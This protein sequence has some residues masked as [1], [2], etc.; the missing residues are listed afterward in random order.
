[1]NNKGVS[2]NTSTNNYV[3]HVEV[4]CSKNEKN[5]VTRKTMTQAQDDFDFSKI[6]EEEIKEAKHRID[7]II[8]K[9]GKY[10]VLIQNKVAGKLINNIMRLWSR[11]ITNAYKDESYLT[12]TLPVSKKTIYLSKFLSSII[13]LF[14][15]SIVIIVSLFIAYYSKENL[16]FLKDSLTFIATIYDSTMIKMLLVVGIIF[17]LEMLYLVQVG[18]LGI[19]V[20]Y[21]SNNNKLISSII[22]GFV[23]YT[24]SQIILV[25]IM[26]VFGIFNSDIMN[27]FITNE[28]PSIDVFKGI[29]YFGIFLYIL[30]IISYYIIC[31]KLFKKGVNVE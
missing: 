16:Q 2:L 14:T 17:F 19:I 11:L 5:V 25:L 15:S 13:T 28:A 27:L 4:A 18:Y 23:F 21:K 9:T 29:M 6:L 7:E 20:G 1:M 8:L 22:Y 26:L 31:V 12:H 10:R 30:L 3:L 24:V